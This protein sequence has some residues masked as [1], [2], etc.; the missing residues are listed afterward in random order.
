MFNIDDMTTDKA[1]SGRIAT[2][3]R[4]FGILQND[5]AETAGVSPQAVVNWM[6]RDAL[7]RTSA[8]RIAARYGLSLDWL[9]IGKGPIKASPTAIAA[10]M[11]SESMERTAYAVGQI[12]GSNGK[13]V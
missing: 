1:L 12:I 3:K 8:E 11:V 13:P 4:E 6:K 10:G 2:L 9:L 7:S 5:L